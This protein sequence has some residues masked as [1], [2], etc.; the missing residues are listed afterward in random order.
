[1][2]SR[3]STGKNGYTLIEAMVATAILA[4]FL[5]PLIGAIMGGVDSVERTRN[6]QVAR[7]LAADKLGELMV[8]AVPEEERQ[9]DGDF[10]PSY[11]EFKWRVDFHKRPELELLEMQIAGLK[12]MEVVVEV[13]WPE[14][15]QMKQLT[16]TSLLAQ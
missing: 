15:D 8:E 14:G 1:L 2:D 5:V 11:P 9:F 6:M 10:A 13:S 7:Q 16:F 12:T 3:N 4:M